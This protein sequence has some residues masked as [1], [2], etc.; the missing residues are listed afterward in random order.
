MLGCHRWDRNRHHNHAAKLPVSRAG[1]RRSKARQTHMETAAWESADRPTFDVDMSMIL[2]GCSL[3]RRYD[4]LRQA[5][6]F[7]AEDR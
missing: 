5:D 3:I 7:E 4:P 2:H 1:G 6:A